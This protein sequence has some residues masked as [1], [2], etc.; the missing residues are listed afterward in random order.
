MPEGP[1]LVPEA[2]PPREP[3]PDRPLPPRPLRPSPRPRLLP[4]DGVSAL[5]RVRLLLLLLRLLLLLLPL[6]P[7]PPRPRATALDSSSPLGR[8][9]CRRPRRPRRPL[10]RRRLLPSFRTARP[11]RRNT[12]LVGGSGLPTAVERPKGL[13]TL[14]R[15]TAR[16]AGLF[17]FQPQPPSSSPAP[18][19]FLRARPAFS[20]CLHLDDLCF[21][22]NNRGRASG[23]SRR[24]KTCLSRVSRHELVQ[25]SY[26]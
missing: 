14:A 25:L 3:G 21:I 2:L 17:P 7:P 8:L 23:A 19:H 16:E 26:L 6:L 24:P 9:P 11:L 5:P 13:V 18:T 20:F 22:I 15:L 10:P 4:V 1:L 12:S